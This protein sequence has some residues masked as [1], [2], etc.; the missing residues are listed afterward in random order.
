MKLLPL[1]CFSSALLLAVPAL[2][3]PLKAYKAAQKSDNLETVENYLDG[4]GNGFFWANATLHADN[5][6]PLFCSPDMA[7]N[8]ENYLTLLDREIKNGMSPKTAWR[9]DDAIE[10]ILLRAL[11]RTFPCKK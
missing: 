2:S 1:L 9:D 3:L 10:V 7:L 4:V 6:E 11:Q 8:Q 5:K